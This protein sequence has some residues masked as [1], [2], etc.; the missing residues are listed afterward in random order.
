[1]GFKT[2]KDT[3][4]PL[5]TVFSCVSNGLAQLFADGIKATEELQIS[6]YQ[7]HHLNA[8]NGCLVCHKANT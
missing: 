2:M 7:K 1:M 6:Y 5:F 4:F 8:Y 3:A